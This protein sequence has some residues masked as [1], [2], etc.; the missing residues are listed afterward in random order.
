MAKFY[1]Q[2]PTYATRAAQIWQ[3]LACK[4]S[5]RQT[6]TYGQLADLIGFK[7]A[8]TL[9]HFLGHIMY[10]CIQNELPPLT[11]LVV[12]Q[13]TGLPGEGLVGADLNADRERVFG[14]DWFALVS[15]T[16]EGL[17]AAYRKKT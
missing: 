9:A 8:G 6:L 17:A 14:Y 15:P 12:K 7:G 11:V 10:Y 16:T 5:N 1:S 13:D 2:D 3:I 4:A